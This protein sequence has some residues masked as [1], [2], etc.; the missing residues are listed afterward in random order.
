MLKIPSYYS[1]QEMADIYFMYDRANGNISAAQRLYA[2]NF[3]IKEFIL[4]KDIHLCY[5]ES[6]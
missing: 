2:E 4:F 6:G 5:C 1:N 3:L